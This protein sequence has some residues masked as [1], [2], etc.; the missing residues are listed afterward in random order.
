MADLRWTTVT[1]TVSTASNTIGILN[2][3]RGYIL[4]MYNNNEEECLLTPNN[5][6]LSL[7]QSDLK[8]LQTSKCILVQ[9]LD[10]LL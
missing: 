8:T 3:K 5:V 9:V 7:D 10:T 1:S 6:P 4:A 2:V